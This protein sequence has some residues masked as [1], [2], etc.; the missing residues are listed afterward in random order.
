M[1]SHFR[2]NLEFNSLQHD[3]VAQLLTEAVA[4]YDA[5]YSK[6][7]QLEQR[8][9]SYREV[10]APVSIL[11]RDVL[12]EI[13]VRCQTEHDT[14]LQPRRCRLGKPI[15]ICL[16]QVCSSWRRISMATPALWS[17]IYVRFHPQRPEDARVT[18]KWTREWLERSGTLP[19]TILID[20]SST[21]KD[22][23]HAVELI[24]S[25]IQ[26]S[27]RF[28]VLRFRCPQRWL[29]SWK[30]VRAEDV[31]IL[32]TFEH[33]SLS[34]AAGWDWYNTDA[35][36]RL[37]ASL[38]LLSATTLREVN[39][40]FPDIP[41]AKDMQAPWIAYE[42]IPYSNLTQLCLRTASGNLVDIWFLL[43]KC[44]QLEACLIA[45]GRSHMCGMQIPDRRLTLP[46]LTVLRMLDVRRALYHAPHF[47]LHLHLP[48]LEYFQFSSSDSVSCIPWDAMSNCLRVENLWLEFDHLRKHFPC[49][50]QHL[51]GNYI[52][53]RLRLT[54]SRKPYVFQSSEQD[55]DALSLLIPNPDSESLEEILCPR[56][57]TLE[58][59][60]G[61]NCQWRPAKLIELLTKR[62]QLRDENGIVHFRQAFVDF[63]DVDDTI[64]HKKIDGLEP[65]SPFKITFMQRSSKSYTWHRPYGETSAPGSLRPVDWPLSNWELTG[66]SM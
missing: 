23:N 22:C 38:G 66:D 35:V 11:P 37:W 55:T 39:L 56:L 27:S 4:E 52:V 16:A 34:P 12:Q 36:Q 10:V 17:T 26:Y 42:H 24:Q 43:E 19:L 41:H 61:T 14:L 28:R 62:L 5:L 25:L 2:D 30:H 3:R 29:E 44:P 1:C 53:K 20:T 57:Q 58:I 47:F 63:E 33:Q 8:I 18:C 51:R 46:N 7:A 64:L 60:K 48:K 6:L 15:Q 65:T 31:P 40:M 54:S 49:L 32:H 50:S 21:T 13:F 45:P 9:Q 59:S